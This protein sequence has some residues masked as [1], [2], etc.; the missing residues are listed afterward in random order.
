M[1]EDLIVEAPLPAVKPR[2]RS[3]LIPTLVGLS[4]LIGLLLIVDWGILW[5]NIRQLS[6]AHLL[7]GFVVY[8]LLNLFRVLRY[9]AL[10]EQKHIPFMGLYFISLYH[11]FFVRVLPFRLGELTYLS[12]MRGHL[13]VSMA[14]SASSLLGSRLL[15]LLVIIAIA[16]L[17]LALSV[18]DV[19]I[20]RGLLL[21]LI[22][23]AIFLSGLILYFSGA[24]MMVAAAVV[25]RWLP[26]L[27]R[28][29]VDDRF[30]Q[31]GL[32]L[33]YLRQPKPF[34]QALFWSLFTY[35]CSFGINWVV[36]DGVG[37]QPDLPLLV[38]LISIGMFATAFPFAI[39]GFGMVEL[40]W[41][42]GLT[43]L[44]GYSASE[45]ASIGFLLNGYQILCA[46][47]AG[48]VAYG[49]LNVAIKRKG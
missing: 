33:A 4:V 39:S 36:L 22:G 34:A 40:G 23:A 47:V 41:T 43:V 35:S 15:E 10:L 9:R 38:T 49:V 16:G 20:E 44:M 31:F 30:R 27:H 5:A 2:W 46:G 32:R 25:R 26:G 6:A 19:G 17:T 48:S 12:L 37:I 8:L 7:T 1:Q 21:L 45:A 42:L 14:A 3:R 18:V 29:Q 24:L 28:W 13:G 11:N